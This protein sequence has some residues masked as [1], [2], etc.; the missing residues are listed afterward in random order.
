[1]A[2]TAEEIIAIVYARMKAQGPVLGAMREAIDRYNGDIAMG[3][4]EMGGQ[5]STVTANLI[6]S[7]IDSLALQCSIADPTLMFPALDGWRKRGP[8]S[9]QYARI[10]RLAVAGWWER[11][12]VRLLKGKIFRFLIGTGVAPLVVWPD[13]KTG[14]PSLSWR[15]PLHTFPNDEDE[16]SN[17]QPEDCGFL[18]KVSISWLKARY[19][20]QLTA[21]TNQML[22]SN[23]RFRWEGTE[24]LDIVEWISA[25]QIARFV[26]T[27]RPRG[28]SV[29]AQEG[30]QQ[31]KAFVPI[32]DIPNRAEV[33]TAVVSKRITLDRVVGQFAALYGMHDAAAKLMALD[34]M[35]H[36]KAV[37]P[38]IV[39]I[40]SSGQPPILTDGDWIDGRYGVNKLQGGGVQVINTQPPQGIGVMLD[41][42]ERNE[43]LE[44]GIVAQMSGEVPTSIQT[45]RAGQNLF[46]MSVSP[47][48]AEYQLIVASLL[49][50]ANERMIAVA[51]GYPELR[52]N[53]FYV[54]LKKNSGT[55]DYDALEH[56]ETTE[57]QVVYPFPGVDPGTLTVALLQRVGAGTLSLETAMM[58][59]PMVDDPEGELEKIRFASTERL[60]FDAIRQMAAAGSIAMQDIAFMGERIRQGDSWMDAIVKAQAAAQKRQ[61]TPAPTGAPETQ[62]GLQ[63][64]GASGV[65]QPPGA[66]A[67]DGTP[68]VGGV[69]PAQRNVRDLLMTLGGSATR[70]NL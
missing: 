23:P 19:P 8:R 55:V 2:L 69:N 48:I 10:R 22:A 52:R 5:D 57:N 60:A 53:S 50:A 32:I 30:T 18:Y 13:F 59:D 36:V 28:N 40:G 56:F 6:A 43:R 41:R 47:R 54:S 68:V 39:L 29:Y 20:E 38:D 70:P 31:A 11:N 49:K 62:P 64:P 37:F 63:T 34:V 33:P 66:V 16:Y 17:N 61:A 46:N 9:A 58:I 35:A 67:A 42:L 27:S 24:S 26:C 12:N 65:E 21:L 3:V 14:I 7:G 45:G 1:M 51:R 15:N 44:G 4:P 25:D